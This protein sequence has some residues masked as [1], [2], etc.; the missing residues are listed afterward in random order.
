MVALQV[1]AK[2]EVEEALK[3]EAKCRAVSNLELC[4]SSNRGMIESVEKLSQEWG[5]D[6][7]EVINFVSDQIQEHP[8]NYAIN[9]G[10]FDIVRMLIDHGARLDMGRRSALYSAVGCSTEDMV[11]LILD[12]GGNDPYAF[13]AAFQNGNLDIIRLL[14]P[15]DRFKCGMVRYNEAKEVSAVDI[16]LR[17]ICNKYDSDEDDEDSDED[18]EKSK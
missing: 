1:V 11:K 4:M 15:D 12:H 2:E 16:C 10:S 18:R 5:K 17:F 9:S 14:V 8:I 6:F 3:E 13:V 7:T